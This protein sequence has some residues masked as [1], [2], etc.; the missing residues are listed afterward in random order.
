MSFVGT[1]PEVPRYV[2]AYTNEMKATLLLPAGVTSIASIA[3]KDEDQLY[4]MLKMLM[5][6]I[7]M[8]FYQAKWLGI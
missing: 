3:Y 4:K 2:A 5:K 8:R 7:S 6:C 1:R